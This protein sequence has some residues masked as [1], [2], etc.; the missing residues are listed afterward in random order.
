[1]YDCQVF[2]ESGQILF[3]GIVERV[4]IGAPGAGGVICVRIQQRG[5]VSFVV[6]GRNLLVI[7]DCGAVQTK[8]GNG[9]PGADPVPASAPG[10]TADQDFGWT[11]GGLRIAA[12]KPRPAAVQ[13]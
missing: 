7:E 13:A 1:M 3:Q 4:S 5:V 8:A 10:R 2:S 6:T 9:A 12:G 11:A